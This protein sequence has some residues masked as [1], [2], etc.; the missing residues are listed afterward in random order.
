[1]F[2]KKTWVD[3]V[4]QYPTRRVL[5]AVSGEENTYDVTRAEGTITAEGDAFNATNMNDFE[6]R[7]ENAFVVT[8]KILNAGATSITIENSDISSNSVLSIY[9]SIYGVNPETVTVGSGSVT[10]TF[11][12]QQSAMIVGITVEGTF[13][14]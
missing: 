4:T 3:R 9:T 10:L 1:M 11:K 8:T 12:A 7:I 5:T 2:I 13:S 14:A 6:E